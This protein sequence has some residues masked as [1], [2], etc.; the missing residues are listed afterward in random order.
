LS[1][2]PTSRQVPEEL[3]G[4][5]GDWKGVRKLTFSQ[6]IE[7]SRVWQ[8]FNKHYDQLGIICFS[9]QWKC[10]VWEQEDSIDMSWDCLQQ[11]VD[12]LKELDKEIDK[13]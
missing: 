7:G 2:E 8:V 5:K 13:E 4:I 6:A 12:K 10:H 9:P 3:G 1:N 11:V